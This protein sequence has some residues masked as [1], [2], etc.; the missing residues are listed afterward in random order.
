MLPIDIAAE[1]TVSFIASQINLSGIFVLDVGCGRGDLTGMLQ[2]KGA[3]IVGIDLSEDSVAESKA[4][5]VQAICGNFLEFDYPAKFDLIV[6]SRSLH[7][8]HP[9]P[10]AA[11]KAA[12]LLHQDGLVVAD[13]FAAEE[14]DEPWLAW[15]READ[16]AI[17]PSLRREEKEGEN[18]HTFP[19]ES[20]EKWRHHLFEKHSVA[21]SGE[22]LDSLNQ[23]FADCVV[24]RVP[25][26]YRYLIDRLNRTKD[27]AQ[28]LQ[29]QI[30]SEQKMIDQGYVGIGLRVCARKP[31]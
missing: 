6:F 29:H 8:L 26:L 30:V 2:G 21:K 31:R 3:N 16:A 15:L 17:T 28:F 20:V 10:E 11:N 23:S 22:I 27:A 12:Q 19:V 4:L 18:K 9:V 14:V 24:L 25:Y 7:H 5:G 13:E 1:H